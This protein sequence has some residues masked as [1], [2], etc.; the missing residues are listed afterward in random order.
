MK[1]RSHE[2]TR[3][4]RNKE[5]RDNPVLTKEKMKNLMEHVKKRKERFN[6]QSSSGT[7]PRVPKDVICLSSDSENDLHYI[8]IDRPKPYATKHLPK[9]LANLLG[10]GA[11]N[12]GSVP[13]GQIMY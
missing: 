1:R 10:I 12:I 11:A 3:R 7:A 8:D 4:K 6:S 9:Q 13:G 2:W 5:D